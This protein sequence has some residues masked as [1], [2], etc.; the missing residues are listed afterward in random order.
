VIL[1]STWVYEHL[2]MYWYVAW[3]PTPSNG[4]LSGVYIGPNLKLSVREKLLLLCGTP[5]NTVVGIAIG[6]DA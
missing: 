2:T 3:P 5:D 4:L 6:S 1:L